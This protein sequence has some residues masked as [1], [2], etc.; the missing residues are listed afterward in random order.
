MIIPRTQQVVEFTT[1]Y[2]ILKKPQKFCQKS[3]MFNYLK[4]NPDKYH[5]LLSETS[6]NQLI[7]E[8]VPIASSCYEKLLEIKID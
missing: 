1:F 4:T 6:E 8:N 3:F 5:V 2:L 7:V